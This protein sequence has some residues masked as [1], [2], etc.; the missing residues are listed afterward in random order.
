MGSVTYRLNDSA[1][2][3]AN[4]G[5]ARDVRFVGKQVSLVLSMLNT[6]RTMTVQSLNH[7]H[8]KL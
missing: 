7:V 6:L 1:K 5:L 4:Y 8:N 2:T 3:L